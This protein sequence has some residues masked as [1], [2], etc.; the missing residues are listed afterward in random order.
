MLGIKE[1]VILE[2][3]L[4]FL[5]RRIFGPERLALL[6]H[7]LAD[8]VAAAWS[9]HDT[10]L[11]RLRRELQETERSLHRQALRLEE[12]DDPYHPVIALAKQRITELSARRDATTQAIADLEATRPLGA[13][14][15]EIETMLAAVPDLRSKLERYE[16]AELAEL[17]DAFDLTATYDKPNRRLKL[18]ATVT[19][20]LITALEAKR[21][22][23]GRSRNCVIAGAGFEQ[24]SATLAYRFSE[25]HSL[26]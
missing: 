1:D 26:A 8:A 20:E 9:E 19:P 10:E 23:E 13:R 16:P 21:P 25:S 6:R 3:T 11:E 4:D 2:H 5:A 17:L 24:T 22:P 15:E 18:A 7:E 14:P 12:H